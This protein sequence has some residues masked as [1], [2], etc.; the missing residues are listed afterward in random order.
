MTVICPANASRFT[1]AEWIDLNVRAATSDLVHCLC[2]GE[3]LVSLENGVIL[4][5]GAVGTRFPVKLAAE[6]GKHVASPL[7]VRVQGPR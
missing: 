2:C 4:V 6:L 5:P 3:L 1:E 7:T